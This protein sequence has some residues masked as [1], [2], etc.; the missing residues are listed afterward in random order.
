MDKTDANALITLILSA[1]LA[2]G[3][4]LTAFSYL[5]TVAVIGITMLVFLL[6]FIIIARF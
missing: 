5:P 2:L 1:L 4:F 3:A 6:S